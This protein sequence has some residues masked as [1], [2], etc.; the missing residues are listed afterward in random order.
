M[1]LIIYEG[2]ILG[3]PAAQILNPQDAH[4]AVSHQDCGFFLAMGQ[5]YDNYL[6]LAVLRQ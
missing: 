2:N 3:G 5:L 1:R 4:A 6:P